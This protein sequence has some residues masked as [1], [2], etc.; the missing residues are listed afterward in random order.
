MRIL[1]TG[2]V[3]YSPLG[4]GFLAGSIKSIDDVP[5]GDFRRSVPRFSEDNL[6]EN[7]EIVNVIESIAVEKGCTP[8]QVALAWV[9]AQGED[10]FPIPGTKHVHR[11]EENIGAFHVKLTDEDMHKLG[12]IAGRTK[13][14]RGPQPYMDWTYETASKTEG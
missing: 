7:L 2:I 6:A 4:R 5:E 12:E 8:G 10:V 3:A 14:E 11:F 9:H 13:G 1:L